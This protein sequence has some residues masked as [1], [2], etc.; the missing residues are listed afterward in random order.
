MAVDATKFTEGRNEG[1]K[2]I[3]RKAVV[4]L[5]LAVALLMLP[6]ARA[7]ETDQAMKLT[8]SQSVQIPGRVLPAGAYWFIVPKPGIV[9]IFSSDQST[10]YETLTTISSEHVE[11]ADNSAISFVERG[12]M[13]PEAIVSWFYPGRTIGNEF[14][15]PK[16]E[17]NELARNQ[18]HTIVAGE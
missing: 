17:R 2:M 8:F 10:L 3:N 15:Y 18:Q 14:V 9:Q 16:K 5:G 7:S 4:L 12:P 6:V 1:E 13:Q 11:P